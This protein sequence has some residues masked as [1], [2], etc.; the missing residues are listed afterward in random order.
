MSRC[1]SIRA[2]AD[3]GYFS[4]RQQTTKMIKNRLE[5][6]LVAQVERSKVPKKANLHR[7][8]VEV[9]FKFLGSLSCQLAGSRR[10]RSCEKTRGRWSKTANHQSNSQNER[11]HIRASGGLGGFFTTSKES[12]RCSDCLPKVNHPIRNAWRWRA[13]YAGPASVV[14]GAAR[15]KTARAR[16]CAVLPSYA[17]EGTGKAA[18][19]PLPS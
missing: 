9:F 2:S 19:F 17:P 16:T 10:L 13:C 3:T 18:R 11:G 7:V 4:L 5:G 6:G 14:A 12:R 1:H 8:F 15:G